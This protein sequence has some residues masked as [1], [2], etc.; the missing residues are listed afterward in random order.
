MTDVER[1]VSR[2]RRGRA[3]F[4]GAIALV[5]T[6]TTF[7]IVDIGQESRIS[8]VE[9]STCVKDPAGRPCQRVKRQSDR[10]RSIADTCIAFWKV[11][12]PCPAPNSGVSAPAQGGDAVQP[13]SAGQQPAPAPAGGKGGPKPPKG[14]SGGP[15]AP[16]Q[17]GSHEPPAPDNGDSSGE[18]SPPTPA[19][20]PDSAASGGATTSPE[21]ADE[22]GPVRSTLG[23]IGRVVCSLT[24]R[25]Q[26]T[27]PS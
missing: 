24:E 5:C 23:E 19:P 14:D 26:G 8:N 16:H 2:A 4:V 18:A 12:Y 17:P 13:A 10:N 15:S 7:A 1:T 27:C 21:P 3:I 6:A 25:L 22:P 9:R 20:G 11:G